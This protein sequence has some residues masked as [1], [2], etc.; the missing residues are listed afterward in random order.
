[1]KKTTPSKIVINPRPP[2]VTDDETSVENPV[3]APKSAA[4]PAPP[5]APVPGDEPKPAPKKEPVI[6]QKKLPKKPIPKK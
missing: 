1:M 2:A 3:C 6:D 4:P 5:V